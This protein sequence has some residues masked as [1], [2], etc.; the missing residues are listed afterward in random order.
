MRMCF[1][2][3]VLTLVLLVGAVSCSPVPSEPSLQPASHHGTSPA[4]AAP[5]EVT[6]G[7]HHVTFEVNE[8]VGDTTASTTSSE[9]SGED[10]PPIPTATTPPVLPDADTHAHD[11]HPAVTEPHRTQPRQT[12]QPQPSHG[13]PLVIQPHEPHDTHHHEPFPQSPVT[14][15]HHDL[16]DNS[17]HSSHSQPHLSNFQVIQSHDNSSGTTL[18]LNPGADVIHSPEASLSHE[19][20]SEETLPRHHKVAE[21]TRETVS[22]EA[23]PPTDASVETSTEKSSSSREVSDHPSEHK[24]LQSPI[25]RQSTETS[26]SHESSER[27]QQFKANVPN[28]NNGSADLHTFLHHHP[29]E[30]VETVVEADLHSWESTEHRHFSASAIKA[31]AEAK[32]PG[33]DSAG[34]QNQGMISLASQSERVSEAL[35]VRDSQEDGKEKIEYI[36]SVAL[37]TDT[38]EDTTD[39]VVAGGQE[40]SEIKISIARDGVPQHSHD[41]A[42]NDGKPSQETAESDDVKNPTP[43]LIVAAD[44]KKES[45]ERE[46]MKHTGEMEELPSLILDSSSPIDIVERSEEAEREVLEGAASETVVETVPRIAKL[47]PPAVAGQEGSPRI[48]RIHSQSGTEEESQGTTHEGDPKV[49]DQKESQNTSDSKLHNGGLESMSM[50]SPTPDTPQGE[51]TLTVEEAEATIVPP[52][53]NTEAD[54]NPVSEAGDKAE[55]T[56]EGSVPA[57]SAAPPPTEDYTDNYSDPISIGNLPDIAVTQ[58]EIPSIEHPQ[59]DLPLLSTR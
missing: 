41:T 45:D 42:G 5:L 47:T 46:E 37:S 2:P 40:V 55:D 9:L 8:E 27:K 7:A 26:A 12:Q 44:K 28:S 51:G 57:P 13:S 56:E 6:H 49:Q 34:E 24:G 18:N 19:R 29:Q 17:S 25:K 33:K 3:A 10:D 23:A 39:E 16:R 35:Q 38:E 54:N 32:D 59:T 20:S 15:P 4:G 48:S 52:E 14:P 21:G 43:E 30:E 31:A 50:T 58:E 1:F 11:A 36:D 53:T 22:E